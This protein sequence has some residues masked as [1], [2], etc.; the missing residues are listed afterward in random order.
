M[1][2]KTTKSCVEKLI[3]EG[4]NVSEITVLTPLVISTSTQLHSDEVDQAFQVVET[5]LAGLSLKTLFE[6]YL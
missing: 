1:T 5:D 4:L 3:A 6:N 2:V